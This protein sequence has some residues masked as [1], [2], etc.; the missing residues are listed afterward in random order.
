MGINR[1]FPKAA[2]YGPQEYGGMA[3]PT[4]ETIQDQKCITHWMRH[5]RWG[6]E[7]GTDFKITL[8]AAQLTSGLTTPILDDTELDLPHLED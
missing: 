7:I 4:I 8:S 2:L 3:F 6:Q 1:H 5:L